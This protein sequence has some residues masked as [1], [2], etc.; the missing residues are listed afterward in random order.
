MYSNTSNVA[1]PWR[2]DKSVAVSTVR[3]Q[4]VF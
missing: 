3:Y 1:Y 2:K 4:P